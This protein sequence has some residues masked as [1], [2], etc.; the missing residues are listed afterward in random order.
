MNVR[1]PIK[2]DG[3]RIQADDAMHAMVS[4]GGTGKSFTTRDGGVTW[5]RLESK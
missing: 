2:E 4:D 1:A 3:V 5:R